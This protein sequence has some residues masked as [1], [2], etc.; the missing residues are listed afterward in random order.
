MSGRKFPTKKHESFVEVVESD[1]E[2]EFS[3]YVFTKKKKG[4]SSGEKVAGD[5]PMKSKTSGPSKWESYLSSI[6]YYRNQTELKDA[7]YRLVAAQVKLE[8]LE[9]GKISRPALQDLGFSAGEAL[10]LSLG[11]IQKRGKKKEDVYM[12]GAVGC[13]GVNMGTAH[14]STSKYQK[15]NTHK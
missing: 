14:F 8:D 13:V 15:K 2:I 5:A 11:R 3:S 1:E 6:N 10:S 9:A 7:E 12:F 4:E